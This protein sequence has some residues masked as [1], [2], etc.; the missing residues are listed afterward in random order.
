MVHRGRIPKRPA[1]KRLLQNLRALPKPNPAADRRQQKLRNSQPPPKS[2]LIQPSTSR[3]HLQR[4]ILQRILM[5]RLQPHVRPDPRLVRLLPHLRAHTPR[6]PR[7]Q[8]RKSPLRPRRNQIVPDRR[9]VQ[10]KL[11]RHRHAHM[12]L[13]NI[14]RPRIALP[15]PVKPGQRIRTAR[16]QNTA[17]NIL[18]HISSR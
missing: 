16:L 4:H 12:V 15:I 18:H 17:Q 1:K 5:R 6:I 9:L 14:V 13:A 8:P 3:Q 7:L 2:Q 11:L 10:Q